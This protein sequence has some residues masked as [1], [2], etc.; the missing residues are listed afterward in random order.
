[1]LDVNGGKIIHPRAIHAEDLTT[2]D[3]CLAYMLAMDEL[4]GDLRSKIAEN[5]AIDKIEC[6]Y[7]D[8][9]WYK[10]SMRF[11]NSAKRARFLAQE[12][13]AVLTKE[14]KARA[15]QETLKR[16]DTEKAIFVKAARILLGDDEVQ[17]IWDMVRE[18]M[19]PE[20]TQ[21]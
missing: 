5:R 11:L 17:R 18:L 6:S 16:T 14:E 7:T 3:E 13:R 15:H 12:R 20:E 9:S 4:V 1:M 8:P 10:K 2:P 21:A 19:C